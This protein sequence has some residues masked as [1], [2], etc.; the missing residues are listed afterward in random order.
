MASKSCWERERERERETEKGGRQQ[1]ICPVLST[2]GQDGRILCHAA[3]LSS[4]YIPAVV[5]HRGGMPCHGTF[6]LH[7]VLSAQDAVLALTPPGTCVNYRPFS[8]ASWLSGH[9]EE[10]QCHLGA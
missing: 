1:G 3:I 10:N 8:L 9:P 7:Q 2:S 5:D 4:S 6:L